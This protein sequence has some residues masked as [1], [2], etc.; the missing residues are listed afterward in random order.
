LSK[1]TADDRSFS[2]AWFSTLL[3]NPALDLAF[4]SR[5]SALGANQAQDRSHIPALAR[6]DD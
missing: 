6:A 4:S 3:K 1:A 5:L 2:E